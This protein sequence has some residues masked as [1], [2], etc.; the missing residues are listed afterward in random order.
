M[1]WKY[2]FTSFEGRINR[3]PYWLGSLT[4]MAAFMVLLLLL[5]ALVG[6][7]GLFIGYIILAI[8][9][10]YPSLALM[11]KRFHDRDKSGWWALVFY[12]PTFINGGVSYSAPESGISMVIGLVTLVVTIWLIIELGFLKGKPGSN[13]YGPNP[14]EP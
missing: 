3:K 1:D 14:L 6:F 4:L 10:I 5:F 12:V 13:D 9:V 2:L 7:F 11:V 8:L